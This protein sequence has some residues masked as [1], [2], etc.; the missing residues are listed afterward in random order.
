L[1]TSSSS[2]PLVGL[3]ARPSPFFLLEKYGCGLQVLTKSK[4]L[5]FLFFGHESLSLLKSYS[6]LKAKVF[7]TPPR[8]F[9][10]VGKKTFPKHHC[11]TQKLEISRRGD[12]FNV[13][14]PKRGLEPPRG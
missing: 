5:V 7:A 1:A 3:A 13:F 11:G 6:F 8:G 4:Q 12:F 2:S 9:V 14:V 10:K